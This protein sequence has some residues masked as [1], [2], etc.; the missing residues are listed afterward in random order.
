MKKLT[1]QQRIAKLANLARTSSLISYHEKEGE[2]PLPYS[3]YGFY[4]VLWAGNPLQAC[5]VDAR[6]G[7]ILSYYKADGSDGVIRYN[8]RRIDN[9]ITSLTA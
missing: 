6:N 8:V 4:E 1:N 5:Y 9:Y 3:H 2:L 7:S